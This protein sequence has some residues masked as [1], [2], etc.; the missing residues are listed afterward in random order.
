[1]EFTTEQLQ[2][3]FLKAPYDVQRV[4]QSGESGQAIID[5]A[6]KYHVEDMVHVLVFEICLLMTGLTHPKDFVFNL[7]E[8][9]KISEEMARTIASELNQ[10]IFRGV[11]ESLKAIHHIAKYAENSEKAFTDGQQHPAPATSSDTSFSSEPSST[12]EHPS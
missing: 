9:L 11:R 10:K 4:L 12:E 1:M 3:S 5:I 8:N 2:K 7:K 6:E